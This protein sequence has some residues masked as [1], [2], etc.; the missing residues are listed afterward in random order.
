MTKEEANKIIAEFMGAFTEYPTS[1]CEFG[2]VQFEYD[3]PL[4]SK[5]LDE[6]VPVWEK[7]EFL[8]ISCDWIDNKYIFTIHTNKNISNKSSTIQE[9][10][11][12]ATAKSIKELN[13]N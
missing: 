8:L 12:I 2:E 3:Y 7:L 6:L 5:S 1:V 9:A 13:G 10:A 4:Y 11:C